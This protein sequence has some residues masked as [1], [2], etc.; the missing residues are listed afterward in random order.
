MVKNS[1]P[2][3]VRCGRAKK[4]WWKKP[5]TKERRRERCVS[6]TCCLHSRSREY[7][8][9]F[10]AESKAQRAK[11]ESQSDIDVG[12]RRSIKSRIGKASGVFGADDEG[13]A[14]KTINEFETMI[15]GFKKIRVRERNFQ[16]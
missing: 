12:T 16:A 13:V 11:D 9:N 5:Q 3:R 4:A 8:E 2:T 1:P 10:Y 14:R 7:K 15:P 6:S